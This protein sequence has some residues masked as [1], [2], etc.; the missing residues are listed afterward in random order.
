MASLDGERV[1]A[2]ILHEKLEIPNRYL[3]RLLTDLTNQG[4]IKSIQGRNGGYQ[5]T[6]GLDDVFLSD[7][8]DAVE[9]I[10]SLNFC[11]LGVHDCN[12]V[13]KCAMHN[14]WEDVK[15][16]MMTTFSNTS[17]KDL[18]EKGLEL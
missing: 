1:S 15:V 7:I 2:K 11:I 17:L 6:R 3:R 14:L 16:K 5:I 13:E 4:L 10:D 12:L 8:I 9:G 18:K